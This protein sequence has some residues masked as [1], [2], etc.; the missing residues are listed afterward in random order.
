M[1]RHRPAGRSTPSL[2]LAPPLDCQDVSRY[3]AVN[4][5]A[6]QPAQL[7]SPRFVA[8]V[9]L[10]AAFVIAVLVSLHYIVTLVVPT[11]S[12]AHSSADGQPPVGA[13]SPKEN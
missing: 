12:E 13:T 3:K 10:L 2:S 8:S 4:V 9:F 6:V 1:D 5:S 7:L 11:G